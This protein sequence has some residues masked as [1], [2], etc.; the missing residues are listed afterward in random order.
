M[1][2][3]RALRVP[4]KTFGIERERYAALTAQ[5]LS[6]WEQNGKFVCIKTAWHYGSSMITSQS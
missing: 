5:P 6:V 1:K 4:V 2:P 3:V